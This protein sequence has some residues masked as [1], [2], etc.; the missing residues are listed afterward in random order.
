[1]KG[2]NRTS[3]LSPP[4]IAIELS[5]GGN[6]SNQEGKYGPIKKKKREERKGR[7]KERG[8]GEEEKEERTHNLSPNQIPQPKTIP[9]LNLIPLC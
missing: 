5:G 4:I 9:H 8:E 1:M 3:N 2:Y 6:Q 7:R